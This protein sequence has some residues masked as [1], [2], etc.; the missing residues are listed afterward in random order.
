MDFWK[1]GASFHKSR[2]LSDV[3]MPNAFPVD[4]LGKTFSILL[5]SRKKSQQVLKLLQTASKFNC[6]FKKQ[7][8]LPVSSISCFN[9]PSFSGLRKKTN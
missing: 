5:K 3:K 7:N 1:M 2:P 6:K 4:F 9:Y 8:F